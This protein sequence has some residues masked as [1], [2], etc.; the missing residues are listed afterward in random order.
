MTNS[1][2]QSLYNT[3]CEIL[4]PQSELCNFTFGSSLFQFGFTDHSD[5][6][7]AGTLTINSCS[8]VNFFYDMTSIVGLNNGHGFVNIESSS[9]DKFS[10]C[11]SIIRDTRDYLNLTIV[12]LYSSN[13][14]KYFRSSSF[15]NYIL[16]NKTVPTTETACTNTT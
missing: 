7:S 12:N 2:S 5:I 13:R 14:T 6:S 10:S 4:F 3:Q 16:Q 1:T 11:G 9:F 8:F 15:S